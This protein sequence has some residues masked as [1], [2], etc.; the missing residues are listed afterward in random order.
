MAVLKSTWHTKPYSSSSLC[1]ETNP[2]LSSNLS[3]LKVCYNFNRRLDSGLLCANAVTFTDMTH[4][5]IRFKLT[6]VNQQWL[7]PVNHFKLVISLNKQLSHHYWGI[8][9][10]ELTSLDT[11]F[12]LLGESAQRVTEGV[13]SYPAIQMWYTVALVQNREAYIWLC[14]FSQNVCRTG[15]LHNHLILIYRVVV[16]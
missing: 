14:L 12:P 15:C 8:L 10:L 7:M 2:H 5:W 16:A 6:D 4:K 3:S 9:L 1:A 13:R 11:N